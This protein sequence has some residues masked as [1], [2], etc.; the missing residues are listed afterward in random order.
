MAIKKKDSK[1]DIECPVAEVL[2]LR[3]MLKV[4]TCTVEIRKINEIGEL[5]WLHDNL[6]VGERNVR[7]VRAL[8][9]YED[10]KPSGSAEGMLAAQMVGT[11]STALD[12]LRRAALTN[13]TFE[14]RNM[15]LNQAQKLMALYTKQLAALDK[16]RGKGQQKVTVEYVNV[17]P[18]GQAIVGNVET[19][20]ANRRANQHGGEEEGERAAVE[21]NA[22]AH[23]PKV[24][25]PQMKSTSKVRKKRK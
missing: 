5:I 19:D 20:R 4:D 9:L 25:M 8:E 1:P 18:G 7:V 17:E 10:L 22:I 14:G 11:H 24:P 12:C 16:H 6:D 21:P 15:A 2:N 23:T 3:E 13:Q